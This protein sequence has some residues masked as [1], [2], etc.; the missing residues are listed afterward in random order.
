MNAY[1]AEFVG[2]A[3]LLGLGNG[4]VANVALRKTK[5]EARGDDSGWLVITLGWG[6]AVFVAV[7][8][9]A[10]YSGAHI[11]PAVTLG[12]ATAGR[13]PWALVPG[14]LVAQMLGAALGATVVWMQYGDH[15]TATDDAD[16]KLGVF[17][18]SPAIRHAL[19]NLFSEIV[20]TFVL[21]FAV[22]GMAIPEVGLGALDALPIGLVIIA[23]GLCL[24][25][26]TGFAINP[27]RD[28]APR[29]MHTLLPIPGKR[30]SDWG[31]AWIPVAGPLLGCWLAAV[32]F[33][34]LVDS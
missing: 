34:L 5:G 8:L 16:A 25:G 28:L 21:V 24:G 7:L 3:I 13:F 12:L 17:C 4:V 14:Y 29:I 6:L 9:T 22:L 27:A 19:P 15:F 2:T 33:D 31:Y 26:P 1:F 23:I 30:D 18:T 32:V 20:G 10:Q 11:N